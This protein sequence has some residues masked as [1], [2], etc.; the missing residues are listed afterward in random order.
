LCH[1][2]HNKPHGTTQSLPKQL[3][4]WDCHANIHEGKWVV[5]LAFGEKGIY[6]KNHLFLGFKFSIGFHHKNQH[7]FKYKTA[8]FWE[9][10]S[11]ISL[12]KINIKCKP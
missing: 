9:P 7:G 6:I 1:F 4:I 12:A 11:N 5:Y 8:Y 3:S 10:S 2:A